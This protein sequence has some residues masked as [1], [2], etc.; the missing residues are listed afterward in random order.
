MNMMFVPH[1]GHTYRSPRSITDI[2][3]LSYMEVM[4]VLHR[5]HTYEPPRPVTGLEAE[6]ILGLPT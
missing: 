3:L 5:K 4:F 6:L 1:K 2:T